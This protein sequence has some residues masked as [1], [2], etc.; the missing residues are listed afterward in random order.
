MPE[1]T[2]KEIVVQL[3]QPDTTVRI[4]LLDRFLVLVDLIKL[5]QVSGGANDAAV[6]HNRNSCLSCFETN[7][8]L[9]KKLITLQLQKT[10][11]YTG[12]ILPD[13]LNKCVI[14]ANIN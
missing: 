4:P 14:V 1:S 5:L 2:K 11:F 13:S 12:F 3:V 7:N 8:L 6:A 9:R 10:G